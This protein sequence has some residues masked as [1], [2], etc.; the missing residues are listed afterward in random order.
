VLPRKM[1]EEI[2]ALQKRLNE[3]LEIEKNNKFKKQHYLSGNMETGTI[4]FTN[5]TFQFVCKKETNITEYILFSSSEHF[6]KDTTNPIDDIRDLLKSFDYSIDGPSNLINYISLYP[7]YQNQDVN[8]YNSYLV[9]KLSIPYMNNYS[10]EQFETTKKKY[11]KVM[12]ILKTKDW[13]IT[14]ENRGSLRRYHRVFKIEFKN[15]YKI[16]PQVSFYIKPYTDMF[17]YKI[18]YI[19]LQ[20]AIVEASII[21]ENYCNPSGEFNTSYYTE[22]KIKREV[23]KDQI[24]TLHWQATGIIE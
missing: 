12:D 9:D 5:D 3:L 2:Q 14:Y 4:P 13:E 19:T 24:H 17:Q 16:E 15:K 18:V 22:H 20:Y 7:I 21:K 8:Y 23:N 6:K 10:S 11:S 1:S